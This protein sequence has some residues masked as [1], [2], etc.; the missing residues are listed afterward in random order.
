MGFLRLGIIN[1]EVL[2]AH[3]WDL[4]VLY[5]KH[6]AGRDESRTKGAFF[7]KYRGQLRRERLIKVIEGN[8]INTHKKCFSKIYQVK[9]PHLAITLSYTVSMNL[10]V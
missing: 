5:G 10:A 2:L 9:M 8:L 6:N 7:K 4:K 1:K 3:S